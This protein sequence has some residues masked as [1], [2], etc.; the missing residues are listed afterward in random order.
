[1]LPD[2]GEG[3]VGGL[4]ESAAPGEYV[5][6]R[7]GEMLRCPWHGW[8]FDLRTGQSWFDPQRTRV[9][10]YPVSVEAGSATLARGPYIAETYPVTIEAQYL[11]VEI[12]R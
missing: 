12:G 4:V 3:R 8:E 5:F 6:S 11:I 9:R 7:P 2:H 10:S 1:M